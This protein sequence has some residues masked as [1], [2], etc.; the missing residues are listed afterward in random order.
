MGSSLPPSDFPPLCPQA[1]SFVSSPKIWSHVFASEVS[2]TKTLSFSH[3]PSKPEVIPFS[4]EKLSKGGDDWSLC[5]VGYSI[6]RR[7]FYESLF[8]AINKTWSLSGSVKLLS[9]NDGFFLFCFSYRDDFDM[10][11]SRGI[12][13]IASKIDI[14]VAADKL[15]EEKTRLTYAR[16]CVLVDNLATYPQEIRVSL[17]GVE[18]KL[19]VQYEWRPFPCDHC[20]SLMHFSSSCPTKPI[21]DENVKAKEKEGN[22]GRSFSRQ[23]RYRAKSKSQIRQSEVIVG[24]TD[25]GQINTV[26]VIQAMASIT[27]ALGQTLHY[28]AH[29]PTPKN[30]PF[31]TA[32]TVGVFPLNIPL[33]FGEVNVSGIPNLNSPH[34]D[35]S[36]SSSSHNSLS[37]AIPKAITSPQNSL[38]TALPKAI[39]SPNRGFNHPDKVFGCKRLIQ[40]FK[41]NLV[42]IL[43]NRINV[44]PLQ[45][46]F[47]ES[48]HS[49]FVDE[50]S[51]HN[52]HLN[53]SG[54]I[55]VKWNASKLCF[56]PTLVSSQ[57]ISGTIWVANQPILQLSVIYASNSSLELKV[58]WDSIAQ[59]SPANELSWALIGDFNCC[60]FT[61]E[62]LGGSPITLSALTDFNNM[63]FSNGLK[64]LNSVGLKYTW[65]NQQS[66][67]PIHI[68]LDRVHHRFLFKNYWTKLDNYWCHLLE[69]FSQPC[70]GNPLSHFCKSLK[71]LKGCIKKEVWSSSTCI[72]RH[73]DELMKKQVDLLGKLQDDHNNLALN[74]SYKDVTA[75]LVNFNSIHTSWII[76]RAKVN[77]L[78]NG[79]DDIKFLFA[80]IR[81]RRGDNK[82]VAN[83]LASN[84][85]SSTS[86]VIS[87]ITDYFQDLYNLVPPAFLRL[88]LFRLGQGSLTVLFILALLLLWMMKLR[89][90]IRSFFKK[91]YMPN[92][93]K[94]TALA[95]IPKNK[96]AT[97]ISDYRPIAFCNSLYKIIA[98]VIA[99][100]LKP[101][102]NSI[103]MDNQAGFIKSRV[104]TDNILLASE[105]LA[106]VGKN[107]RGFPNLFVNWIKAC[108]SD[109]NF[110]IVLNGALEGY[111]SSSA[112]LRQ[113]CPLSPYLFCLVMDAFSN[114][115]EG[116]GFKGISLGQY[117]INHLLYA[118]DVLIFGEASIDNCNLLANILSDFANAS[119]FMPLMDRVNKKMNG[120]KANLLSFAGRLQYIKFTIQNTIAYWIRGSILPKAVYKYFKKTSSRFLFFGDSQVSKKLHMVSWDKICRPKCKGGLSIPSIF[121]L[122]FAYN[123]AVIYRMY[124]LPSLLSTWLTYRYR[125][126]WRPPPAFASKLWHSICETAVGVKSCFKFI[127]THNPLISLRWDH[128]CNNITLA[129]FSGV[130]LVEG[131]P[132]CSLNEFLVLSHWVF[133]DD[134]PLFFRNICEKFSVSNEASP[135][136]IW[137]DCKNYRFNKFIEEY[138]ADIPN[139]TCS[140]A[141]G[142]YFAYFIAVFLRDAGAGCFPADI[143]YDGKF[144]IS[145]WTVMLLSVANL[146]SY[147]CFVLLCSVPVEFGHFGYLKFCSA[148]TMM[149]LP[150]YI[151]WTVFG[152]PGICFLNVIALSWDLIWER[153]LAV[154]IFHMFDFILCGAG[155]LAAGCY[156]PPIAFLLTV[157]GGF[158]SS[159]LGLM[160]HIMFFVLFLSF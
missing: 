31:K 37:T 62:K 110:S 47:F 91:C 133:P 59:S 76:Q 9:L 55:W 141:V 21:L 25:S 58:L 101:I 22:R 157:W 42:S 113:G 132:D 1:G 137:K 121:A 147:G 145:W 106:Y 30:S 104:S 109:V 83:L 136:L 117:S 10:V 41:L 8:R 130:N 75:E 27:N 108:I 33:A 111:F 81:T 144:G 93:V 13:R 139:C 105:I 65:F 127:I 78:K 23:A 39:T 52:F 98:K 73:L 20:K 3:H 94:A 60:R 149:K 77:W 116:R 131:I 51:Y 148:Y 5:L 53:S 100:R 44:L 102:M 71:L 68:K 80:K 70:N 11:W 154:G 85:S 118:D 4:C 125:S 14:P 36:S 114:L 61:S 19:K 34:E 103:V 82:S 43:E 72:K 120:W 122:Q 32:V 28:Q 99:Q 17:D 67:N 134:F 129:E 151:P 6:G 74:L 79:E 54:R 155:N 46:H 143:G 95:I 35:I 86:D 69:V 124:N 87:A 159:P 142:I 140:A 107:K 123:C 126:P 135:C 156:V 49:L 24:K 63:F 90:A 152:Q 89:R 29:S 128:W 153:S 50:A 160:F 12:S 97:L 7:P 40:S 15:T 158:I 56:K 88:E 92:G 38:S 96:N 57:L 26:H 138:Y 18:V 119:D 115:L 146:C 48:S 150:I 2:S 64:D 66:D 45:D 84:P 112:G 16:I